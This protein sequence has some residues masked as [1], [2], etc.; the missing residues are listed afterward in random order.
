MNLNRLV[1]YGALFT[2]DTNGRLL[3]S[4]INTDDNC[5]WHWRHFLLTLMT[6]TV[7]TDYTDDADLTLMTLFQTCHL[8]WHPQHVTT[9]DTDDTDVEWHCF[10]R[11]TYDD[12]LSMS[13][14]QDD[15]SSFRV[16]SPAVQVCMLTCS[17]LQWLAVTCCDLQWLAVTCCDLLWL[18]VT[19][20]HL[21]LLSAS[22]CIIL[23]LRVL[24]RNF[25]SYYFLL[26]IYYLEYPVCSDGGDDSCQSM[27]GDDSCQSMC[28]DD[29][30]QSMCGD[31]S[32]Q[33]M[34]HQLNNLLIL[35]I[36]LISSVILH[37]ICH[38]IILFQRSVLRLRM[39]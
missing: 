37:G 12:I 4:A 24:T 25:N 23:W 9:D 16:T 38:F 39:L 32:C 2:D 18:A 15:D 19:C 17:D 31:D 8:W 27:C 29:S 1:L 22:R 34:C 21:L 10:S 3:T 30:C 11:V 20:S 7:D 5:C 28:G 14:L 35:S 36:S 26:D 6:F 33:S 13:Q